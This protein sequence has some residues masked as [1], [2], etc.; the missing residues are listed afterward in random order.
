MIKRLARWILGWQA[1]RI[2]ELEKAFE[3]ARA[4]LA[5][6]ANPRLEIQECHRLI[7]WEAG[8][9]IYGAGASLKDRLKDL[10]ERS[11]RNSHATRQL[12]DFK[13]RINSQEEETRTAKTLGRTA[14]REMQK[15]AAETLRLLEDGKKKQAKRRLRAM[16]GRKPGF[17][18]S[19]DATLAKPWEDKVYYEKF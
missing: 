9:A 17:N 1:G 18:E 19:I 10:V 7:D 16:A 2:E 14:M 15:H 5:K 4:E 8:D 12:E 6:D 13:K 3:A 11:R